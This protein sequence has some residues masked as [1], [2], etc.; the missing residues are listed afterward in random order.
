MALSLGYCDEFAM[1]AS[2]S[3]CGSPLPPLVIVDGTPCRSAPGR[4]GG[5]LK[6]LGDYVR[7]EVSPVSDHE[8]GRII[9]QLVLIVHL[10]TYIGDNHD[11]DNHSS[12]R[13]YGRSGPAAPQEGR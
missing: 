8:F 9:D 11:A 2:R 7:Q 5:G 4:N 13:S 3:L 1:L 12:R 6:V 10:T